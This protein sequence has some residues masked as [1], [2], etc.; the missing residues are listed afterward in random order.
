[1][2]RDSGF[3]LLETLVALAI[4]A[5]VAAALQLGIAGAWRGAKIAEGQDFAIV[6]AQ[7]LMAEIGV[8]RAVIIGRTTGEIDAR[9]T[10]A[11]MAQ[12]IAGGGYW[13]DVTVRWSDRSRG[14]SRDVTLRTMK[15]GG[16]S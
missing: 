11:I 14:Q 15:V 13:V 5:V 8:S 10:Y 16:R 4:F 9:T 2:Q 1:M 6:T 12:P 7:R 3:T